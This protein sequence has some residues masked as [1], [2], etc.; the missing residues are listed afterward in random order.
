MSERKK[1][2]TY[3]DEAILIK[4]EAYFALLAFKSAEW[5]LN[6]KLEHAIHKIANFLDDVSGTS[7]DHVLCQAFCELNR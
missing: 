7:E 3:L 2:A 5:K 1:D 4:V 6:L